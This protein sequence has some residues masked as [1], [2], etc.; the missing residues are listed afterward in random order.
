M[1]NFMAIC[2]KVI[3]GQHFTFKALADIIIKERNEVYDD[4][5][6]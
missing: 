6:D 4:S 3:L 5:I 1:G 2:D